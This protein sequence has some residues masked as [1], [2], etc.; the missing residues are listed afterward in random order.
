[1]LLFIQSAAN[2]TQ[3]SRPNSQGSAAGRPPDRTGD[4]VR[5]REQSQDRQ[6]TCARPSRP[7]DRVMLLYANFAFAHSRYWQRRAS[8][9]RK[10]VRHGSVHEEFPA[11][12][13]PTEGLPGRCLMLQQSLE[14]FSAVHNWSLCG[15]LRHV[16][17]QP[18]RPVFFAVCACDPISK[19]CRT[20]DKALTMA[21]NLLRGVASDPAFPPNPQP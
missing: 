4:H 14:S 1:M 3:V 18:V 8:P 21:F 11:D 19:C 12:P 7:S 2:A 16:L 5:A 13:M 17:V 15:R 6:S 10:V 9:W 20:Y